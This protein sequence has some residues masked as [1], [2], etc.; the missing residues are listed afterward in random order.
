MDNSFG[1]RRKKVSEPNEN[2]DIPGHRD[3]EL[4]EYFPLN[5]VKK[6]MKL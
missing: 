6:V 1:L 2:D 3:F 4:K 5:K